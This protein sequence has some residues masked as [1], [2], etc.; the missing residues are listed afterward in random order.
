MKNKLLALITILLLITSLPAKANLL[1]YNL[2]TS[3]ID[4]EEADFLFQDL[5]QVKLLLAISPLLYF[6]FS[7][8]SGVPI[9]IVPT[10]GFPTIGE[11]ITVT[12]NGTYTLDYSK[13]PKDAPSLGIL[14]TPQGGKASFSL[15]ITQS[16]DN[17]IS[18]ISSSGGTTTISTISSSS[19]GEIISSASS[20]GSLKVKPNGLFIINLDLP[21]NIAKKI[22]TPNENLKCVDRPCGVNPE[23]I[24]KQSI[25]DIGYL[26]SDGLSKAIAVSDPDFD[27]PGPDFS[28]LTANKNKE[29][30]RSVYRKKL[31]NNTGETKINLT[32][33]YPVF[34]LKDSQSFSSKITEVKLRLTTKNKFKKAENGGF[35]VSQDPFLTVPPECI[36]PTFITPNNSSNTNSQFNPKSICDLKGFSIKPNTVQG[37]ISKEGS[38]SGAIDLPHNL[39]KEI[40]TKELVNIELPKEIYDSGGLTSDDDVYLLSMEGVVWH[41]SPYSPAPLSYRYIAYLTQEVRL[42]YPVIKVTCRHPVD[43]NS[44]CTNEGF[45]CEADKEGYIAKTCKQSPDATIRV[46]RCLPEGNL[47]K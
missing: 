26:L 18:T 22:Y 3:Y 31:M 24:G 7:N 9:K 20:S 35:Y 1:F 17:S 39:L 43:C 25:E 16:Q 23:N 15:L 42:E 38:S 36:G 46:C 30:S 33:I 37:I 44:S 47:D 40:D 12:G 34:I 27:Y 19:S 8:Y 6:K 14:V 4:I 21:E 32:A 29:I 10:A 2:E 11:V 13:A 45:C 5:Q 28:L 41:M